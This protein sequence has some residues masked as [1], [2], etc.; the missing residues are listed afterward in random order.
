MGDERVFAAVSTE[1]DRM[2]VDKTKV[3]TFLV[4]GES[5]LEMPKVLNWWENSANSF[6]P[7]EKKA[8]V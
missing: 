2:K 4:D 1:L 8:A 5:V 7:A 3:L 6:S